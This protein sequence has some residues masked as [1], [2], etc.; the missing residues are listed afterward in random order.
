MKKK[1]KLKNKNNFEKKN[2]KKKGKKQKK[3][4]K[5]TLDYCC[6]PQYFWV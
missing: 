1:G 4:E 3:K 2:L 5:S 6:N